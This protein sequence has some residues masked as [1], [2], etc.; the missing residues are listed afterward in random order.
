[1][2]ALAQIEHL[3]SD[4]YI[5]T[6]PEDFVGPSR[7]VAQQLHSYVALAKANQ[8]SPLR[9]MLPGVPGVGKS[10]LARYFQSLLGVHP[11]W[12]TFKFSGVDVSVDK[13]RGLSDQFHL[14]DLFGDWRLIWIEEADCIP[15]AAQVRFL[16]LMDEMPP[17]TAMI[18]TSNAAVSELDERFQTRFKFPVPMIKAPTA[19]E[20]EQFIA[21]KLGPHPGLT[22]L[23]EFACGNMRAALN[24]AID[25]YLNQPV[26]AVAK[27]A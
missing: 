15:T 7:A 22:R 4:Q 19:R 24:D 21:G 17:G 3:L 12:S 9:I 14:R 13:L 2:Q 6:G 10:A 18:C 16:M 27:A 25:L 1:M 20:I 5:P 23:C 26:V 11:K 8:R